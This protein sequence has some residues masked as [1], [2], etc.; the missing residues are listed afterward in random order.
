MLLSAA[1][2]MTAGRMWSLIGA[3]AGVFGVVMGVL[4]LRR[5]RSGLVAAIAGGVAVVLGVVVV[6]M[7]KGGPGTGYGIVGGY[8][9]LVVG[10][11]AVALGVLARRRVARAAAPRVS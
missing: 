9:S 4:A 7:A 10:L 3:A 1:Y 6:L 2:E 5:G 11:A 8:V